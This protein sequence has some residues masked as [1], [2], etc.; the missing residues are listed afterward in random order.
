MKA[1]KERVAQL[2][3]ELE[4]ARQNSWTPESRADYE[5]AAG[6]RRRFDVAND[7]EF[8]RKYH[9]P[10]NNQYESILAETVQALPDMGKAQEW[11]Q[12]MREHYTPDQLSREWWQQKVLAQIPD[13][14]DRQSILAGVAQMQ[15][16]M[17]ER[18]SELNRR[19]G[20]KSA[21][22]EFRSEQSK[23]A[24]QRMQ[25]EIK[26]EIAEREKEIKDYLPRDEEAAK[27]KEERESIREHNE[28]FS[29][30]NQHFLNTMQDLGQNG[31]RAWVRA[32]IQATR[33]QVLEENY[34]NLEKEHKTVLAERD[35]FRAELDKIHGVRRKLSNTN[36]TPPASQK[37][38]GGLS[39]KDL[40]V[41]KAFEK[42]DWG[43]T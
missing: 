25:A 5:H 33:A 35:K 10:I 12:Y 1:E 3:R 27:T 40:D 39:I 30:L 8:I 24:D 36:G 18:D 20:D 37:K 38:E 41:R 14:I 23:L 34:K 11:A 26:A 2:S 13:E 16:Q 9:E 4:E 32:S 42:Y 22:D 31:Y 19:A 17:K 6:V 7:P 43:D 21:F 15:K 28:R 29:K